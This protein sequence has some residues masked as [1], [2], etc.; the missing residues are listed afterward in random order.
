[1]DVEMK[2]LPF[3]ALCGFACDSF[4]EGEAYTVDSKHCLK[5]CPNIARIK[6]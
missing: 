4:K 1:M 6:E 3:K 5:C 2:T